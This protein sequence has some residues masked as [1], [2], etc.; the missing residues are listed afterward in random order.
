MA[1]GSGGT[2]MSSVS[3]GTRM[4]VVSRSGS[5]NNLANNST[6]NPVPNTQEGIALVKE[7]LMNYAKMDRWNDNTSYH[8]GFNDDA[9][10][11]VEEVAKGNYGF[12]SQVAQTATNSPNWDKYGY[13][14]SEKQAYIIARAAVENQKVSQK[15]VIF[16]LSLARAS[17]QKEAAK[18]TAKAAKYE[19]Y[20]KN[21]TKSKTKVAV[22]S[23]VYDNKGN[24]GVI[25]SI[26]TKSSGYVTVK[27]EN[28][29]VSKQMAFNL[30]GEDG[31]P[32]KKK[33]KY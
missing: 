4:S 1:K 20:S 5:D 28:G 2:R 24:K 22:G 13:R 6:I 15:S 14:L 27:Y 9:M 19:E 11:V 3:G 7:S 33:P 8:M 25:N 16:D 17:K 23:V 26:I 21:Y 29:T 18:A 31:N 30:K 32:L 10:Q 12:A